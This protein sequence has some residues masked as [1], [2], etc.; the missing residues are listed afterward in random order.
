M[1]SGIAIVAAFEIIG[2]AAFKSRILSLWLSFCSCYLFFMV[3]GLDVLVLCFRVLS[4]IL[5]ICCSESFGNTLLTN[6]GNECVHLDPQ[7]LLL[8]DT[9]VG[10]VLSSCIW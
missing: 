5:L 1:L 8:L 10:V 2:N 6:S 3:N 4:S 7:T 9:W